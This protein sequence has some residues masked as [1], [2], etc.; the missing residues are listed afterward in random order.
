LRAIANART[1]KAA[2]DHTDS[3]AQQKIP[4]AHARQAFEDIEF[5]P[6]IL[7]GMATV[8]TSSTLLGRPMALSFAI[9]TTGF[10]R[11]I[12]TEG[13]TAGAGS[14][15]AAGIPSTSQPSESPPSRT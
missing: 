4:L 6:S 14:A 5:S 9:A 10:T 1:P 12:Q 13:E 7:R 15:A 3:A 11:L 2:F 8:D